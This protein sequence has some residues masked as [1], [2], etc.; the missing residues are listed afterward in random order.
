MSEARTFDPV[1]EERFSRGHFSRYPWDVVVSFVFSNYPRH[2][3]RREVRIFEAG[4]GAGNNLWF[5]AREGFLVGGVDASPTAIA[6]ARKR[7]EEEGL[8]GDFRTGDFT[9]LPFESDTFDLALDRAAI[10]C[11][12]FSAAR[13]AVAEVRRILV[14]GGRFFFN[15]YSDRHS[16]FVSGHYGPDGLKVD[17]GEGT[18]VGVGQIY[19]YSRREVDALFSEGWKLLSVQHL[20]IAEQLRPEYLVHAEW[21]VVAEKVE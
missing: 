14:P 4:C 7:F 17:I 6:N 19:F 2:K 16:S 11:C 5:A 1:W 10:T 13:A 15:P 9:R 18:L 3:P 20:E 8:S 12:G 21:R